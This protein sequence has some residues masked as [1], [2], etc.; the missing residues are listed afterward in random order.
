[1]KVEIKVPN[2]GESITEAI[3]GQIL[4]QSGAQVRADDEIIELETDKVNQVLYA[5]ESGVLSLSVAVD[6]TVEIGQVIGF[7]DTEG[8]A[9]IPKEEKPE[10]E[11][12]QPPA[13]VPMSREEQEQAEDPGAGESIRKGNFELVRS[14]QQTAHE[15][16]E[17]TPKP[18]AQPK[19]LAAAKELQKTVERGETRRRMTKIRRVIAKRL[20]EAQ[21]NAAMLTTFNE[22]DMSQVL[23]LRKTYK[24]T[25][26]QVHGVRLGFM[27]LFVKAVVSALKAWPDLNSYIDGDEIVHR[28]YYDIGIA[29]GT[30]RGLLVPV[31]RDCDNL[32]IADIEKEIRRYALAARDGSLPVDALQGGG[33]TI[34]NGGVYGSLLSTPILNPPQSGILG[35]HSIQERPVAIKGQVVIRPMMNLAVSYDHRIVDGQGAVSFLVHIKQVLENLGSL[36]LGI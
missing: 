13:A 36:A 22:V 31:V 17:S 4:Q 25:F 20:V 14:L 10:P 23:E 21:Q 9:A 7:V 35:M 16:Q 29:V 32:S 24:D 28:E 30:D 34:T 26:E 18:V 8:A 19:P 33:F 27:S 15:Q 12:A 5:P 1:M 11:Q 3:V 6:D 2:M